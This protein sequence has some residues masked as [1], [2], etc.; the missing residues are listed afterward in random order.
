VQGNIVHA[1]GKRGILL[2]I[3]KSGSA[4]TLEVVEN[5][6]KALPGIQAGLPPDMRVDLMFDQSLFVRAAV[7]GV[8]K[9]AAI[10][11]GLTGLMILLFLG[12][13]RSTLI[14]VIS[15]PLSILTSIIVLGALGQ[16]MNVMDLGGM[17]LAVGILVDDAT[18]EIENIHRN[19]HQGKR[20]VQAI[21]DGARQI[22]VPAFVSTLCICIVFVPVAFISGA[23]KYLFTPLAM[24]VV[25]AMMTSYLLSRTLVPT[26]VRFFLAS[27]VERYGGNPETDGRI[28]RESGWLRTR[29]GST[30]VRLAVLAVVVAIAVAARGWIAAH[31]GTVASIALAVC[32]A[33]AVLFL[34]DR[35]DA[36]WR[37]HYAF[38]RQFERLRRRYGGLLAWA[39]RH[40]GWVATGFVVSV[41]GSCLLLLLIGQD[42]FPS[43]D[44]GQIR[45]HVRAPPGTRIEET[46]NHFARVEEA[47]RAEIPGDEIVTVLDNMGIPNSGINLSL[48]DGSLMSPADGE[49]LIALKA[50]H[51]PTEGY[52]ERLRRA[53]PRQFP[54]LVFFFQPPDIA[55]QVLNFGLPAAIDVQV[56]GPLSNSAQNEE[57]A[58]RLVSEIQ[59]IPG[60]ADVHLQQVPRAPDLRVNVD[61][62]LAS[63]VG[64]SQR[65]VASDLLISLSSSNQTAPNFWLNPK[66]GVNYSIFVQT[67]QYRA[68]SINEL[69][70]TPVMATNAAVAPGDGELLGNLATFGRG[71]APTNVTHYDISP[72]FDVLLGVA[73]TDLASV[74]SGVRACVE[75]A[76]SKLPRGSTIVLRGQVESMSASFSGLAYGLVFAVILVYLLM[77]INFQSWVDPLIILMALPGALSGILWILFA[78]GTTISVPALT[79]AIMSIGVATANSILMVTFAND[80]RRHGLDAHDAALAAGLTRLRPV[81][82][83]ALAMIIGMLPMSLGLGEGSEQNAPLGRAVIGGLML[84]TVTTLLFVPVAYSAM[85]QRPP[86]TE[87]EKEL[88]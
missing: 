87:V 23:A 9:E 62:T 45:L 21:L 42:F 75:E 64:V 43:V 88:A 63:Q 72:T 28:N 49:I 53:L 79:G 68:N 32:G 1:D 56:A 22:A 48:S 11:A 51:R 24:A 59:K 55:T 30:R 25:F 5:V 47:I 35:L 13:W 29:L 44:A 8:V 10:A 50:E 27:E 33:A 58:S 52:V 70:N 14:V 6:R 74:A 80:Q 67:P 60:A 73:G 12:S 57:I 77:V 81:V 7:E 76:R 61:R 41:A 19:L 82:M 31:A 38:D 84:A 83:T 78:T 18:V 17:A 69:E 16:T 36:I 34:I 66:N 26:L 2:S 37:I 85:R 3:L 46:E 20:L 15:I 54:E 4:S 65:D 86:R 39:L 71:S 40:R